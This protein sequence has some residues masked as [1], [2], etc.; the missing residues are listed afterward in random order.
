VTTFICLHGAGG[1]GAY[2]RL[3]AGELERRGHEVVAPDL[4]CDQPVGLDVYV[5]TAVDAIGERRDVV[6][7]AQSLAGFVAPLVCTRVAV[8]QMVLV[9]AM[10]PRPGESG[11]E[12]W[13]NTGHADAV[14][15]LDLPDD[16][17]ETLF[18]H[19]V[20]PEVL[21]AF[22]PPRDQTSTLFDEPWPLD[23]WPDVPTQF[24][25]CRDDRF[26][27]AGWLRAVVED[28]LGIEPAVIPGG[29]CAFL[30]QPHALAGAILQGVT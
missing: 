30:S 27:P 22:E 13:T 16:S 4:P 15:A 21:A 26:F 29:H 28:R 24:I 1:R 7:V 5:D 17:P 19:D 18:T 10:V 9:A 12:W 8:E 23:A 6:I 11:L 20:P 3:V 25:V 2:W 14:A